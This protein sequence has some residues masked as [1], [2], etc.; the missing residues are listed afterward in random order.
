MKVFKTFLLLFLIT[1]FGLIA[2]AC[3]DTP[4]PAEELKITNAK[5]QMEVGE[6]LDLRVS[7]SDTTGITVTPE[8]GTILSC[9]G[10][11]I[12][13]LKEGTTKVTVKIGDLT[14]DAT[15]T[16]VAKEFTVT[17]KGKDGA[18]LSTAKV[19]K[20]EAAT[21]PEVSD[22]DFLGWDKTFTDVQGDLVVNALF[23]T[24][25]TYTV[26]FL[27][28]ET[29]ELLAEL[30]VVEG[31]DAEA[32]TVNDPTFIGWDKGFTNVREDLVIMTVHGKSSKITYYLSGGAFENPE[33]NITSYIEGRGVTLKAPTKENYTF[34]GWTLTKN[35]TDYV[36][37]IPS[38]QT[39]EVKL[40]A[41]WKDRVVEVEFD[42]NGGTSSEYF[43]SKL[44]EAAVV[45]YVDNYNS[46][47]GAFW[48]NENY[49]KYVFIGNSSN[50]P[51]ATFSDRIYIAKDSET[52]FYKVVGFIANGGG[53]KW[54]AGAE[55]VITVSSSYKAGLGF[56]TLHN[57]IANLGEEIGQYVIFDKDFKEATLSNTV[58]VYIFKDLPT[59]PV[60]KEMKKGDKFFTGLTILG[61]TFT[62]WADE[63]GN[64][65][66]SVDEIKVDKI[67]LVA[68]YELE[69][70]VTEINVTS[71]CEEMLTGSTFNIVA[72][73]VPAN[74]YFKKIFYS[75]SDT[76]VIEV[77]ANGK[78]TAKNIGTATI[79]LLDY[80][81]KIKV[82]KEITVYPVESIDV[83][84]EAADGTEY[85]G[86]LKVGGTVTIKAEAYGKGVNN[87]TYTFVSSDPN[88]LTV[89]ANGKVTAVANGKANVKITDNT[90]SNFEVN[91]TIIVQDLSSE[92]KLDK[93]LALK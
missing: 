10:L 80:V 17:F 19:K 67:K 7:V 32:P 89:D 20:G 21:A 23:K 42:F 35:G 64:V 48:Q 81:K 71:I 39:G 44:D 9:D 55:Y 73:V 22:P 93:V 2:F 29:G 68:Q 13:A 14:A 82:E 15:I 54:P 58:N 16:V 66:T 77:D 51:G 56:S 91:V 36:T 45:M 65:Y 47:G 90:G 62:G 40:Y 72:N 53:S 37:E 26:M 59:S 79:T 5:A 41:N 43:M 83:T 8:D 69:N 52:G 63:E 3:G 31:E 86:I 18:V 38:T 76:D 78:L 49:G 34:V 4:A 12:T 70:P 46:N 92:E 6:A 1:A 88:V 61:G 27:N 28:S 74:A 84:F 75:S 60:V 57:R 25:V 85:N 87:P 11:K 50:D 24:V 33:D 30:T